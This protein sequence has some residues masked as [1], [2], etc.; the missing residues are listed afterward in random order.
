MEQQSMVMQVLSE[1][2]AAAIF[3]NAH[4][5]AAS[6]ARVAAATAAFA[7]KDVEKGIAVIATGSTTPVGT[8]SLL[9][10][11]PKC[12]LRSARKCRLAILAA[13]R[14]L[15]AEIGGVD[16]AAATLDPA[17]FALS[18]LPGSRQHDETEKSLATWR[19]L[20][21]AIESLQ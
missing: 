1:A 12:Q 18:S 8:W 10:T 7:A 5:K 4:G 6:M 15:T 17:L 14:D 9:G 16:A 13:A 11:S 20:Q 3:V 2:S 19:A 21:A